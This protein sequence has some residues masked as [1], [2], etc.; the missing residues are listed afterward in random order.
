MVPLD[1]LVVIARDSK[2][3]SK[4]DMTSLHS[5]LIMLGINMPDLDGF[6]VCRRIKENQKL[7]QIPVIFISALTETLDKVK[8]FSVGGVDYVT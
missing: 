6:E 2:R 7:R 3:A 8:A 1:R 5:D 4:E